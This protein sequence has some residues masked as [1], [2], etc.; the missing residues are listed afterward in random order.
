MAKSP[1]GDISGNV[2]IANIGSTAALASNGANAILTAANWFRAP[3]NLKILSAWKSVAADDVTKGTATTSASYRRFNILNGSTDGAGTVI[4][5]SLNATASAAANT[6]R[7]FATTANNTVTEG[8]LVIVSQLTVGAATAD[9][10]DAGA[11]I[12][13]IAYEA[14]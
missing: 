3:Y 14:L 10:T 9:G 7:G 6:T 11:G 2:Y 8:N 12:F 1:M 5:A 4:M 13:G